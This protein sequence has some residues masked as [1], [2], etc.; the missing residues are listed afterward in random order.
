MPSENLTSHQGRPKEI[1]STLPPGLELSVARNPRGFP[2]CGSTFTVR[3]E[4]ARG[5]LLPTRGRRVLSCL[6]MPPT[7]WNQTDGSTN[8]VN[9]ELANTSSSLSFPI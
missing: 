4:V 6:R 1:L 7:T 3:Y 8:R 5:L 2:G 9:W